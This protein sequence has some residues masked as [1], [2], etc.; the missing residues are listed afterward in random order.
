MHIAAYQA[1]LFNVFVIG[2]IS[3]LQ[4]LR[5]KRIQDAQELFF[6]THL[7]DEPRNVLRHMEGEIVRISFN[8]TLAVGLAGIEVFFPTAVPVTGYKLTQT[9]ATQSMST[10]V[11][12]NDGGAFSIYLVGNGLD[13]LTDDSFSGTNISISEY[14]AAT[15]NLVGSLSGGSSSQLVITANATTIGTITINP[16][17]SGGDGGDGLTND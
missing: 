1:G 7:A 14:D 3:G 16:Y 17:S 4:G 9:G 15:H 5:E 6:A 2:I 12:A 8:E 13:D 10:A 11:S